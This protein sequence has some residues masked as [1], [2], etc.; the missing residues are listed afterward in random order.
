MERKGLFTFMNIDKANG[1]IVDRSSMEYEN[2][3]KTRMC[4]VFMDGRAGWENYGEAVAL[5]TS[6]AECI[7]EVNRLL[8][9]DATT[10][11]AG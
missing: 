6:V 10:V 3:S 2:G 5:R 9:V 4:S 8:F 1:R 11:A 7:C